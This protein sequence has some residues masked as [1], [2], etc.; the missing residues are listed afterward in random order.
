VGGPSPP[1]SARG[2]RSRCFLVETD[3]ARELVDILLEAANPNALELYQD[4]M[5]RLRHGPE[6]ARELADAIRADLSNILPG[7]PPPIAQIRPQ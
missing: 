6:R 1:P 5:S 2:G 7:P 4:Y 3:E